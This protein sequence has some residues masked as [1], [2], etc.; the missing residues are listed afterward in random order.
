MSSVTTNK[1]KVEVIRME[2]L[3]RLHITTAAKL[4]NALLCTKPTTP[5]RHDPS[6]YSLIP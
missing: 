3:Q 4:I 1:S 2:L 5:N 6:M